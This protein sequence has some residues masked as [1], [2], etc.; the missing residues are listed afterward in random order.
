M[1]TSFTTALSALNSSSAAVSVVGNNLANLNT[2]GFKADTVQ[3][4]DLMSQALGVSASGQVGLGVG[5]AQTVKQ[6][7]QGSVQQTTGAFDAAI[8]GNGFFVVHDQSGQ[9]LYTRA[10]NFTLDASGHLQTASGASVQGWNAQSGVVNTNE[11]VTDIIIPVSGVSPAKAT[12]N[13]SLNA[14]LNAAGVIGATS[15][16]YSTPV[17][18]V[19][20]QGGSHT[21]T[22]T[23][24][25]TATNGWN[26]T[27]TIPAEDLAPDGNTTLASGALTFDGAGRLLTPTAADSP[28]AISLSNLADGAADQ[29]VDWNLYDGG[30]ALLTQF[31][32]ISGVSG[33]SQDGLTAGQISKVCLSNG[34]LLVASYSNGQQ[35]TVGQ[36]ALATIQNPGTLSA[37]GNNNLRRTPETSD[38]AIGAA[39]SSGRGQILGSSLEASTVDVATEFT[40]LISFQ[41]TYQANSK[42]VTTVDQMT[43]ELL[44]LIR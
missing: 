35:L 27:V 26:Y 4:A 30:S 16:T 32:Q 24:D 12:R 21:L 38:P 2:T 39:G 18:V 15:G 7:A 34:G 13:V 3:F 11:P 1:F 29:S 43:Q 9:E 6:F 14:N 22:F 44:G 8:Q 37:V 17:K 23:F 40:N 10:G 25:K 41:R 42:V 28:I 36:L 19:D 5:P 31:S 33:V 20:A